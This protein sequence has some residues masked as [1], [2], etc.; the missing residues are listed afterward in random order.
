MAD[1]DVALHCKGG[2][3]PGGDVDAQVLQVGDAEAADVAVHPGRHHFR[4]VGQPSHK[5]Y[6]QVG[7]SQ[8]HQVAVGG[9]H[10]V[11]GAQHHQHHHGIAC[12]AHPADEQHQQDGDH[13]EL[14]GLSGHPAQGLVAQHGSWAG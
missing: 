6:Q 11:L 13:L 10:H 14:Q 2:D 5:Q 8:A 7:H 12:Y 1:C 9:G 4:D 3:G